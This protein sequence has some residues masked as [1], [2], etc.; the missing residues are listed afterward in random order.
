[1]LFFSCSIVVH[2]KVTKNTVVRDGEEVDTT[3]NV[4][5]EIEQDGIVTDAAELR[6]DLQQLVDQFLS[7]GT[8][9]GAQIISDE[10]EVV[11]E[12]DI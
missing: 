10:Q 6:D 5:T 1:M 7:D 2:K 4:E 3:E 12:S 8:V 9:D 11:D